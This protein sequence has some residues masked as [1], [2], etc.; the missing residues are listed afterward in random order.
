MHP[1][2]R[3]PSEAL[4]AANVDGPTMA[5]A[6]TQRRLVRR[7]LRHSPSSLQPPSGVQPRAAAVAQHALGPSLTFRTKERGW[8][9]RN[10]GWKGTLDLKQIEEQ[11]GFRKG[12]GLE[13]HL[14]TA[15]VN[16]DE[17]FACNRPMRILSLDLC[18]CIYASERLQLWQ[19]GLVV[20]FRPDQASCRKHSMAWIRTLLVTLRSRMMYHNTLLGFNRDYITANLPEP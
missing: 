17:T 19:P 18:R 6:S 4:R 11:H 15:K 7:S 2:L 9:T 3:G 13:E 8:M 16:M 20:S 12:R 5:Y 10:V 14:L 1:A